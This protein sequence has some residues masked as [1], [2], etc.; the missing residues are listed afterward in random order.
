M[1][2]ESVAVQTGID[3]QVCLNFQ[4]VCLIVN[5]QWI[6]S[7]IEV[8]RFSFRTPAGHVLIPYVCVY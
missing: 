5:T 6:E 7:L 4:S 3:S 8:K 1:K 2:N